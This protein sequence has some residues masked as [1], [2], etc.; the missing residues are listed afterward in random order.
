MKCIPIF[1]LLFWKNQALILKFPKL[2]KNW[3]IFHYYS[4]SNHLK[5][6][7]RWTRGTDNCSCSCSHC[8]IITCLVIAYL[9]Y[10]YLAHNYNIAASYNH[11]I[12][13]YALHCQLPTSKVNEKVGNRL[14][15]T[16]MWLWDAEIAHDS[17]NSNYWDCW[18]CWKLVWCHSL[19]LCS[20]T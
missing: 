5:L 6:W 7:C 1:P 17:S 14:Q 12:A 19:Q 13:I 4:F 16:I 11:I 3:V 15:M 10:W 18:N 20:L 9:G 8:S 2:Y